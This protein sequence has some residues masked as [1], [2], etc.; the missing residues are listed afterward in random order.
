MK[1]YNFLYM[2]LLDAS[3]ELFKWFEKNSCFR[4]NKKAEKDDF[5]K[6]ILVTEDKKLAKLI[7]EKALEDYEKDNVV[8]KIETPDFNYWVL[9]KPFDAY[10]QTVTL[11]PKTAM[12]IATVVNNYCDNVKDEG[13]KCVSSNIQQKDIQI[14]L[15]IT[16]HLSNQINQM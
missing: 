12:A 11:D 6:L 1:V 3:N 10:Q 2:T 5:N 15:S 14:L 9:I 16:L 13:N 8:K 7:I 4:I